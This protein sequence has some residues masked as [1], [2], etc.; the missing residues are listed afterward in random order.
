MAAKA[1]H[2]LLE[3]ADAQRYAGHLARQLREP[4]QRLGAILHER[5]REAAGWQTQ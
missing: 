1:G 5:Q 3:L 4:V 2:R